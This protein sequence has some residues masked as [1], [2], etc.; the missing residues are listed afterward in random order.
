MNSLK[1][2]LV[3]LAGSASGAASVLGSWQVCHNVCLGLIALL[4]IFGITLVGMPFL[5]LT[6][7]A[8]PV[9]IVAVVLL[10]VTIV[11]HAKKKCVSRKQIMF[12][13][14]L[15]V[16]GVPFQPTGTAPVFWALGGTLIASAVILFFYERKQRCHHEN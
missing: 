9:W 2:R 12:N 11:L 8:L 10:G 1:N 16:A 3:G 15:I 6:K 4:A 14:G 5:F 7:I 13:A